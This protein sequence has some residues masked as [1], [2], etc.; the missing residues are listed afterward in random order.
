MFAGLFLALVALGMAGRTEAGTAIT[1]DQTFGPTLMGY[2]NPQTLQ[3]TY[4]YSVALKANGDYVGC[5]TLGLNAL[6][7]QVTPVGNIDTANFNAP[8]GFNI[9]P[10]GIQSSCVSAV[11]QPADQKVVFAGQS[12]PGD[13]SSSI[14]VGRLTTA[15]ALDTSAFGSPNGYTFVGISTEDSSPSYGSLSGLQLQAA[16]GFVVGAGTTLVTSSPYVTQLTVFRLDTSGILDVAFGSAG[17]QT[18]RIGDTT[19][20]TGIALQSDGKIVVGGSVIQTGLP[21]L[22]VARFTT[23]GALDLTYASG[24][25]YVLYSGLPPDAQIAGVDIQHVGG[26]QDKVVVGAASATDTQIYILRFDTSGS[27]DTTFG[28]SGVATINL[29]SDA[30]PTIASVAV[31]QDGTDNI[32]V[33]GVSNDGTSF[34]IKLSANGTPDSTFGGTLGNPGVLPLQ[35]VVDGQSL[36]V[37]NAGWDLSSRPLSVGVSTLTTTTPLVQRFVTSN[38]QSVTISSPLNGQASTTNPQVFVNGGSTQAG[39]L[40]QVLVDGTLTFQTVTDNRGNWNAGMTGPLASGSHTITA[41]LI[42]DVNTVIATA[43]SSINIA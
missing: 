16:D 43:S 25:G 24:T 36:V 14:V 31:A 37:T 30:F 32:L 42:Y 22:A 2:L 17:L 1:L 18:L 35:Q 28:S 7:A 6:V 3:N 10:I 34:L 29:R 27:L 13:G 8:Q 23:A 9:I 40:V 5:G 19:T 20:A 33:S 21:E 38:A 11:T 41:N 26:N 4:L 12:L 39:S 15:G